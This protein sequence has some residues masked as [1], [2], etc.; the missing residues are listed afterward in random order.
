MNNLKAITTAYLK[1]IDTK[2][3]EVQS[4]HPDKEVTCVRSKI[5]DGVKDVDGKLEQKYVLG[6]RYI[7]FFTVPSDILKYSN[8][9]SKVLCK[10][11]EYDKVGSQ[12]FIFTTMLEF[13]LKAR[14]VGASEEHRK[15]QEDFIR[16]LS[17]E[18][19]AEIGYTIN[20]VQADLWDEVKK[21]LISTEALKVEEKDYSSEN[22]F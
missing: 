1:H 9:R 4:K 14:L 21:K 6:R 22:K 18:Q 12:M 15:A 16:C 2:L 17:T 11:K 10:I 8:E 13:D 3:E 5:I 7:F 20:A 19:Q